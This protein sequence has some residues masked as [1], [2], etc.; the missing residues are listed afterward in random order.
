MG[1]IAY[2]LPEVGAHVFDR[3]SDDDEKL[4]VIN[5]YPGTRAAD[6]EIPELSG[7]TVAELNKQYDP[8]APVVD[9]VYVED[10]NDTF[11]RSHTTGQLRSAVSDCSIRSYTFPAP[12]LVGGEGR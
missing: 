1:G 12:R 2:T 11:G 3:E 5:V 8:E 10:V 4:V 6:Y 7:C 9:A